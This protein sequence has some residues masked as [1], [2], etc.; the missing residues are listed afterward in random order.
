MGLRRLP[1]KVLEPVSS[2]RGKEYAMNSLDLE[3][4]GMSCGA[5]VKR[6][7]QALYAVAG[8]EDVD[9]RLTTGCVHVKG[10]FPSGSA[11]LLQALAAAGYHAKDGTSGTTG[12]DRQLSGC[13][14][15]MRSSGGCCCS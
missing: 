1:R 13:Q 10:V 4:E 7:S 15:G 11:P 12:N 5:C 8:V 3:V 2:F 14:T 6:V 9:V